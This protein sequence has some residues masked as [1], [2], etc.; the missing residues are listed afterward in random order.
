MPT[1]A[2]V[3]ARLPL[4]RHAQG[5][6]LTLLSFVWCHVAVCCCLFRYTHGA[7]TLRGCSF[8]CFQTLWRMRSGRGR[9]RGNRQ[10]EGRD[11]TNKWP[12]SS[13]SKPVR[14]CSSPMQAANKTHSRTA[15]VF[16]AHTLVLAR[17]HARTHRVRLSPPTLCLVLPSP[18][19]RRITLCNT[20]A[21]VRQCERHRRAR[22]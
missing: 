15:R 5:T 7:R 11:K 13:S 10:R 20:C 2:R 18:H 1:S 17:C 12:L 21:Q 8:T 22:T 14:A 9:R 16:P 3:L 4:V 6:D 19:A